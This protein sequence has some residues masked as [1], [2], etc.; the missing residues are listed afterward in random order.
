M[1][2]SKN[3]PPTTHGTAA[4]RPPRA[5][6]RS[7]PSRPRKASPAPA[8]VEP[9]SDEPATRGFLE[10][11]LGESGEAADNDIERC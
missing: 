1:M 4:P 11:D 7:R 8:R 6:G 9:E 10:P 3:K 5:K 2:D